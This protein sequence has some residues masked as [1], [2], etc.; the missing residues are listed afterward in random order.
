METEKNIRSRARVLSTRVARRSKVAQ[1]AN[2][3]APD[4]LSTFTDR[5]VNA[6]F[7]GNAFER[8]FLDS[9]LL[10]GNSEQNETSGI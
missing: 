9:V 7:L 4:T 8:F 5:S 10:L 3:G 2:R 6:R 1:I